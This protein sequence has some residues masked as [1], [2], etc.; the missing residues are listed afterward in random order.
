M[1]RF[2]TMPQIQSLTRV[3]SRIFTKKSIDPGHKY[4]TRV[5]GFF[6]ILS[7]LTRVKIKKIEQ[8]LLTRVKNPDPGQQKLRYFIYFD[9]GQKVITWVKK[10]L[11]RVNGSTWVITYINIIHEGHSLCLGIIK[12]KIKHKLWIIQFETLSRYLTA[13]I[14][15]YVMTQVAR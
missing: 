10:M 1:S 12:Q 2:F 7:I 9:P 5:K 11:T 8:F 14:Y 13:Y 4:L 3:K 6:D 15:I